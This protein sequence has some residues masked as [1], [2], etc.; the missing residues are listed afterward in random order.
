MQ[1][2]D[3]ERFSATRSWIGNG[4]RLV[5]TGAAEV[6][7]HRTYETFVVQDR[8]LR[9]WSTSMERAPIVALHTGMQMLRAEGF[10]CGRQ[11]G[12]VGLIPGTRRL[13]V[14]SYVLTVRQ[15]GVV[16]IAPVP[17]ARKGVCATEASD[18]GKVRR[19]VDLWRSGPN[20]T[21]TVRRLASLQNTARS[22]GGDASRYLWQARF[23][24]NLDMRGR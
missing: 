23:M 10:C 18:G 4:Q 24:R 6:S 1:R 20:S 3:I 9:A 14:G 8:V 15:R 22:P 2:A 13:V 21:V 17:Y 11:I 19:R 16:E 12:V 7:R 5:R